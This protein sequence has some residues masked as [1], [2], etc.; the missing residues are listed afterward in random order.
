MAE[1]G[2]SQQDFTPLGHSLY[3]PVPLPA[4][5][6]GVATEYPPDLIQDSQLASASNFVVRGGVVTQR[7]GYETL[8]GS[9]FASTPITVVEWIPFDQSSRMV[10][11][12][13]TGLFLYNTGS[14]TFEDISG[15]ARIGTVAQPPIFSP[16]RTASSGLRLIVVSEADPPAWWTGA[17]SDTFTT[18]T[19]AVM[20]G[21]A[22]V[23]R[24][25]FLQGDVTTP[26]DGHVAARVQWSALGDPTTWSGTSSVGTLDLLDGDGSRIQ[27]FVPLR[28]N[29]LAYK[30]KG[31]HVLFY[32]AAPLYFSQSLLHAS[33]TCLS[34]RA[35][36]PVLN[37]DQH[38][39]ITKE[40]IILWDGQNLDRVGDPI[41]RDI[42]DPLDWDAVG[43]VFA[44]YNPLTEEVLCGFPLAGGNGCPAVCWIYNLRY[45]SWWKTDLRFLHVHPVFNLW[46][47][48][49]LIGV[50]PEVNKAYEVFS[51]YGDGTGATAVVASL[52]TK[53][54]DF[55][56]A[57]YKKG[58]KQVSVFLGVG[59][60]TTTTV[61]VTP[62]STENPIGG[63]L[64]TTASTQEVSY[65]GGTK[66]P[67]VDQRKT[68]KYMSFRLVH[69]AAGET[70]QVHRLVP[71]VEQKAPERTQR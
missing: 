41:L 30:E 60:G 25:H 19:T 15:S 45:K 52:Q 70:A 10:V 65:T 50:H 2:Q 6:G 42:Y 31:V 3:E 61:E 35:V 27:C 28:G 29:L 68:G 48:P 49:R 18:L 38:L 69:R 63:V 71:Y 58:I 39:V 59:T 47:P 36:T 56:A 55:G 9:A 7:P 20:G 44:V 57:P 17:T 1:A 14:N 37:G 24:S 33:L 34:R 66:E 46:S 23:W 64:F 26:A 16:M 22:T 43:S 54:Y 8:I 62:F 13:L 4:P 12:T 11:A 51:G 40:N 32:R 21:C 53:L 67:R 5:V